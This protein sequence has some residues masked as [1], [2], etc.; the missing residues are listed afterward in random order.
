MQ[1]AASIFGFLLALSVL[2]SQIS[3]TVDR[4][5]HAAEH[6]PLT[7]VLNRRGFDRRV[8]DFRNDT[9]EGA[10]IACD[11]DHF[12]RINDVYGHAAGDIVLIGLSDLLRRNAPGDALV[13]RF[14]GEE[15][16]VFLP[17]QTAAAA[18]QL[19]NG[20]RT[21]LVARL[22]QPGCKQPDNG[23]LRCFGRRKGGIIPSTTPS[24]VPMTVFMPQNM[25]VATKSCWKACVCRLK[26]RR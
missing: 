19:A 10:V 9:P 23:K 12:K 22:A 25:A 14:G 24:S 26:A 13:A 17:G 15:F 21:G 16:V 7:D 8:P 20:M 11:I 4:H 3:V 18:G 2:A 5:L 6:D 1:L